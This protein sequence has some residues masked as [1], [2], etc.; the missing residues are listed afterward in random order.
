MATYCVFRNG[1][2]DQVYNLQG[3]PF[4][5]AADY[6]RKT[7]PPEY[8]AGIYESQ[9]LLPESRLQAVCGLAQLVDGEHFIVDDLDAQRAHARR[10]WLAQNE[11]VIVER[12]AR[13]QAVRQA[14]DRIGAEHAS[15]ALM[16]QLLALEED[17]ERRVT[18]A[19]SDT[20]SIQDHPDAARVAGMT[21]SVRLDP[22]E[23]T[24]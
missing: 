1:R 11:N 4:A 8:R 6:F 7:L 13:V 19:R 9:E 16:D 12:L 14:I 2:L 17:V 5:R 20:L 24:A 23:A 21:F 3:K 22:I 10:I 15:M 18:A